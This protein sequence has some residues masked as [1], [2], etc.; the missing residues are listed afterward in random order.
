MAGVPAIVLPAVSV[1]TGVL[2]VGDEAVRA[3]HSAIIKPEVRSEIVHVE[4]VVEL[5]MVDCL[6]ADLLFGVGI[7]A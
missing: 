4:V 1:N 6:D 2:I 7:G 5:V 3:E